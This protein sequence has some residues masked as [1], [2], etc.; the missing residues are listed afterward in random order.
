MSRKSTTSSVLLQ[1]E[2]LHVFILIVN[3]FSW[4]FPLYLL[5]QNSLEVL[6]GEYPFLSIAFGVHLVAIVGSAIVGTG[7]AK[8]FP[9][10]DAFLTIWMLIGVIVSAFLVQ[11]ETF[12][13]PSTLVLSFLLGISLGLGL[14]SSF[15]YFG[16][17]SVEENRGWLAGLTFF[18]SSLGILLVG[19]VVG[20][21]TLVVGSF[22]LVAWRGIGLLLFLFTKSNQDCRKENTV[23]VSYRSVLLDKSFLLYLIPWIMFCLVNFIENPV[24]DNFFGEDFAPFIPLAEYGIGSFAAFIGGWFSDFVGRKRVVIFGF[25]ILGIG[26]AVLG[27][28]SSINFSRHFYLIL[29]GVA[30]GI[31]SC[32]FFLVTWPELAGNRVKEKYCFIGVVPFI[33]SSYIQILFTPYAKLI[34]ISAAFS[35]ASLFLFLAV[36]PILLAPETLPERKIELKRLRKYVDKAKRIKDKYKRN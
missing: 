21:S 13:T 24:V 36:F 10:R 9:N 4:Y 32:M 7:L 3:A 28:F 30:W 34:D 18:A 1:R 20:F 8:R 17:C 22:I 25:I 33:I 15:A 12:N 26:Y 29:D 6:H 27:L 35:L 19:L 16:D 11:L 14:P 5:F 31:F 2:A 23:E